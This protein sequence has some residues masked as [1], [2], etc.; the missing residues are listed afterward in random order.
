[1]NGQT[2]PSGTISSITST[3]STRSTREAR[4]SSIL[5]PTRISATPL[6]RPV[7]VSTA[8]V[9]RGHPCSSAVGSRC[10]RRGGPSS[11]LWSRKTQLVPSCGTNDIRRASKRALELPRG[12]RGSGR[13]SAGVASRDP[14]VHRQVLALSGRH[15]W[16]G[17]QTGAGGGASARGSAG[18]G[19][20]SGRAG[21]GSSDSA[22]G[23]ARPRSANPPRARWRAVTAAGKA[24]PGND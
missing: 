4:H 16:A 3:R 1:M 6:S 20:S 2:N 22:G 7:A 23:L 14:A 21:W 8:F 15:A 9:H 24:K 17:R 13:Q 19:V 18:I 12:Q 5:S 10:E 11:T